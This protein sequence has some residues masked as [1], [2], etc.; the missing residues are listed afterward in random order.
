MS[1]MGRALLSVGF[2]PVNLRYPS[3]KYPIKTLAERFIL[4]EIIEVFSKS[5]EKVHFVTHSMGGILLRFAFQGLPIEKIGRTVML[6][7][8]NQGSEI[9]DKL[10]RYRWFGSFFGP[11]ALELGTGANSFR[12]EHYPLPPRCGIIAGDR[13]AFHLFDSILPAPH[14]GIVSVAGTK[15]T[16]SAGHIVLHTSH[17]FI[18]RSEAVIT[19]TLHFLQRGSFSR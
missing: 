9:V 4:P 8:P 19:E 15:E 10:K 7:P 11:A 12:E 2:Y 5:R 18:M 17:P 14:D 3:R 13:S 16:G 6:A 1:K